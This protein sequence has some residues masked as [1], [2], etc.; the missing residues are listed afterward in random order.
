MKDAYQNLKSGLYSLLDIPYGF[1]FTT[2]GRIV[3]VLNNHKYR[4]LINGDSC[5]AIATDGSVYNVGQIVWILF[6]QN[7]KKKA[8]IFPD[9]KQ[10]ENVGFN[11][12]ILIKSYVFLLF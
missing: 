6:A 10:Q 1:D 8:L 11:K 9:L 5:T 4:V 7:D 3:E 12:N 2:K